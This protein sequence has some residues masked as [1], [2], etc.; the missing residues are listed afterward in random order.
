MHNSISGLDVLAFVAELALI[1]CAVRA[2]MWW[3]GPE[4]TLIGG[5]AG[6]AVIAVIWALWMAPRAKRRLGPRGRAVAA[7]L[8]AAIVTLALAQGPIVWPAVSAAAGIVL[9]TAA[10]RRL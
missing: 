8:L 10:L 7:G 9:V 1:V 3:A 2:G 6:G 5:I 4:H